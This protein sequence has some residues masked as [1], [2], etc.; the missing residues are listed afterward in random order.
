MCHTKE[1]NITDTGVIILLHVDL[2]DMPMVIPEYKEEAQ[3]RI[4]ESATKKVL[5]KGY[6]KVNMEE[7]AKEAGISRPTLYLYFKNKEELFLAIVTNL[8][9]DIGSAAE[10]SLL[11]RADSMDGGFFDLVNEQ[12]GDRFNILFEILTSAGVTPYMAEKIGQLHE[13]I[14]HRIAAQFTRRYP[15]GLPSG[16]DPYIMANAMLSLF[17][18][19]KVRSRL[20]L[21]PEQSRETWQL[22]ISGLFRPDNR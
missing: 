2:Y 8:I 13:G 21:S 9:S 1:I 18:G 19:L 14:L 7:I 20:G 17:I 4:L 10:E 6:Q 3:R 5:E 12:Y 22:V 15:D 16:S 11:L